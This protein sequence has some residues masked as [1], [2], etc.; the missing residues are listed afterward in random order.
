MN[1]YSRRLPLFNK[2]KKKVFLRFGLSLSIIPIIRVSWPQSAYTSFSCR[3]F[4]SSYLLCKS[5]YRSYSQLKQYQSEIPS[6]PKTGF[7][8]FLVTS[9]PD[10][11]VFA[12]VILLK[13]INIFIFYG[14]FFL[15][16]SR[17]HLTL[18]PLPSN[19]IS[20]DI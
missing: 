1:M 15:A 7:L 6:K 3:P 19:S 5:S 17:F 16:V 20:W 18:V 4:P 11:F 10:L 2:H 9:L 12:A 13:R 8:L 14:S